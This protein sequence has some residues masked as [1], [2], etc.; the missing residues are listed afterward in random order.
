MM[1][2]KKK[3]LFDVAKILKITSHFENE[4]WHIKYV[5]QKI[6]ALNQETIYCLMFN[7]SSS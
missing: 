6:Y 4:V 7:A 2:N 1:L 3:Y 5:S